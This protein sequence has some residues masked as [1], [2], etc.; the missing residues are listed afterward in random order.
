MLVDHKNEKLINAIIYFVENTKFCRK[1]KLF[2]LLYFLD[3]E[4]YSQTGRSVTGLDYFAWPKG[5]VPKEL[6]DELETPTP[7]TTNSLEIANKVAANGN[8]MLEIKPKVGFSPNCF[9]KREL[10]LL[11]QLSSEYHKSYANDMIE[12]THLENLPWHE[13]YE[14]Q[15]LKQEKIPYDLALKKSEYDQ[16]VKNVTEHDE[17]EENYK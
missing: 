6:F 2:K 15:N 8:E 5:P 10:K 17:F 14:A 12:A 13:I 7:L 9:S 3:F 4:H 11:D 16:I 1:T